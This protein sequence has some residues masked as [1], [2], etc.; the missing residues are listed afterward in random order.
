M[1]H[2]RQAAPVLGRGGHEHLAEGEEDRWHRGGNAQQVVHEDLVAASLT[3]LHQHIVE[4]HC[5]HRASTH[6]LTSLQNNPL[7]S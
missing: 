7:W 2:G 5:R 1:L 4:I 3:D 6:S